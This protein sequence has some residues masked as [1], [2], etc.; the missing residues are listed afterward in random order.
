MLKKHEKYDFM[1]AVPFTTGLSKQVILQ[2]KSKLE[3]D[4]PIGYNNNTF[5]GYSF[6]DKLNDK[7]NVKYHVLF[8]EYKYDDAKKCLKDK[9]LMLMNQAKLN[10]E[11]FINEKEHKKYL[12][13]KKDKITNHYT[14]KINLDR[15]KFETRHTGW[16]IIA[17]NDLNSTYNDALSIYRNKDIV[18]KS[19]N[20]IKN[21]LS[22]NRLRIH[23][24][25]SLNGKLFVAMISLIL[26]SYIQKVM[27]KSGLDG[28][29]TLTRMLNKLET[30]KIDRSNDLSSISPITKEL[31]NILK[32]F[33]IKIT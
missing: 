30:I 29:Y 4:M 20:R 19:F 15:I 1:I 5:I 18:E 10:P 25:K 9:A 7:Y 17:T 16:L 32:A 11:K 14:I 3:E 28:K 24:S 8:N 31:R 23:G 22:F 13:F 12:I 27:L 21:S 26:S 33:D 2:G 6:I